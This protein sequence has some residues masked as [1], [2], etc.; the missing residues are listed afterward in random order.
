[1]SCSR[2]PRAF[3]GGTVSLLSVKVLPSSLRPRA[4]TGPPA[5]SYDSRGKRA[6]SKPVRRLLTDVLSADAAVPALLGAL[7]ATVPSTTYSPAC[8]ALRVLRT[9]TGP[10][11]DAIDAAQQR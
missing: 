6:G 2:S 1:M 9:A 7:L 4:D 3:A 8:E 10:I 11:R 5:Y